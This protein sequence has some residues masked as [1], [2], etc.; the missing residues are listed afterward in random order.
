ME[1]LLNL[2]PVTSNNNLKGLRSLYDQIESRVRA[3]I[4]ALGIT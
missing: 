1:V 3:L 4:K 2:E